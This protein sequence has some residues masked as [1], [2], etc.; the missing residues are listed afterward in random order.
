MDLSMHQQ[1]PSLNVVE[2][3]GLL[4]HTVHYCRSVP[5][6]PATTRVDRNSYDAAGRLVAQWDPRLAAGPANLETVY[7]LSGNPLSTVSVDAGLKVNLFAEAGQSVQTWDGR[8]SQRRTEYDDQL[9]PVEVFELTSAGG[10]ACTERWSYGPASQVFADHNQCGRLIRQDDPAGTR[11]FNELGLTGAVLD[12][13]QHFLQGLQTPDWPMPVHE[14]DALLEPGA[15]AQSAFQFNPLGELIVQTDAQGNRQQFNQTVDGLLRDVWLHLSNEPQPQLVS[16]IDYNAAGQV[17]RQTL[18]NGVVSEWRY[19][20]WDGRLLCSRASRE[21][22]DVLQDLNYDYDPVGNLLSIENKALPLRYFANQRIEPINC[23][24]Y[25]SLYQ[26]ISATGWEAGAANKGPY[27][28][29]DRQAVGNYLQTYRYDES[30]NLLELIHHG[31]QQH[32]RV[33]TAAKHSN[34]CLPERNGAP[35]TD[36]EIAAAF[37]HNG[38]L[39]EIEPGRQL[40]WDSRN[41][42]H[43]VTPVTRESPL[44]D[45]EQYVYG[46]DGMRQ[47]KV[48]SLQTNARTVVS[49]T[50]YLPGLEIRNVDGASLNVIAVQAGRITVQVLHWNTPAPRQLANDQYRYNLSD[51]LGS[52]S[53]ELDSQAKVVSREAYHP[54]GSTA[55]TERG[56]SSEESY[57]TL[58]YSGQERDATGLYYYGLR[59][60][61]PWL[62]RWINPDPAGN[63]DGLNYF[64]FVRN[65]PCTLIDRQ[66]LLPQVPEKVDDYEFKEISEGLVT[67]MEGLAKVENKRKKS[68]EADLKKINNS[69]KKNLQKE[70]VQNEKASLETLIKDT[71]EKV[72]RANEAAVMFSEYAR[73]GDKYVLKNDEGQPVGVMSLTLDVQSNAKKIETVAA[74]IETRGNG[75][76]LIEHAVNESERAGLEGVVTLIDVSAGSDNAGDASKNIYSYFGFETIDDEPGKMKLNPSRSAL[77]KKIGET[78]TRVRKQKA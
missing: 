68:A 27:A 28:I 13:Q 51:H 37:D 2:P 54:F 3:R 53:L 12:Q 38:N 63:I 64:R 6:A 59:Y 52:C 32:G 7:S 69:G 65:N 36:A 34:R 49:D 39:L 45:L 14:R 8:G 33:L 11:H 75:A 58:R 24:I 73:A 66:G 18:G 77:W 74:D 17:E 29:G 26:L 16:R 30:G 23:Y 25:D 50:R 76:L 22:D 71:A 78:W 41:Q 42:L 10:S 31:P 62:S 21:N 9:R 5:S 15:G 55:Y 72:K 60:Y 20:P 47:R 1:T 56:D 70:A 61:A 43:Q 48:R 40:T 57:R 67:R 44:N 35:P 19:R 46:A 4:I